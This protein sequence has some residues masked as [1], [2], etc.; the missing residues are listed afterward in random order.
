MNT[1]ILNNGL[2]PIT[3]G[4]NISVKDHTHGISVDEKEIDI[5]ISVNPNKL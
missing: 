4:Y 5:F 3:S 1:Y 2:Q